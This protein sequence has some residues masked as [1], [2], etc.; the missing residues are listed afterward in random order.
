MMKIFGG[1]KA[2]IRDRVSPETWEAAR[3]LKY[4]RASGCARRPVSKA[5]WARVTTVRAWQEFL[6]G[7]PIGE[8]DALEISPERVTQWRE[9]GFRS[10]RSV[11][12][13][14]F[15]IT[16][17]TLP[18]SFNIIIAEHVFEHLRY[19]YAAAR[20]VLAML[21]DDGV[22]L[23]VTPFL[24]R[25]H[26]YS[27]DYT[28]W[29]PDGLRSFLEDCGFDAEVHAWG[30]RKAVKSNLDQWT[31]YGWGRDL[32]NEVDVPVCVWA[33]ARKRLSEPCCS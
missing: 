14:E 16:E 20:N 27:L 12:F 6:R 17:K 9:F 30:N 3:S 8:F 2:S 24:V 19:P 18:H 5:H 32:R 13:P 7:L 25:V 23:I 22:F 1:L 11:Q 15:D 10:Y 26:G 33:F 28:R 21:K 29:T 31:P 4:K